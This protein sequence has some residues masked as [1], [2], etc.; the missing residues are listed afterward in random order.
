MQ[1][2]SKILKFLFF[3]FIAVTSHPVFA[4]IKLEHA[5]RKA[6]ENHP[7][8][9]AG[10]YGQLGQLQAEKVAQ[11]AYYPKL[12]GMGLMTAGFPGSAAA[13]GVA[14][15]MISPFHRGPSAGF[16][17][18]QNIWDFGR[19]TG[20]VRLAEMETELSKADIG[21]TGLKIG[22]LVQEAYFLCARDRSLAQV[23]QRVAQESALVEGEVKN[24]VRVGQKSVVDQY[25]LKSQ[26]EEARTVAEDYEKRFELD[27]RR[28]AYLA[29]FTE[30]SQVLCPILDESVISSEVGLPLV[31]VASAVSPWVSMAQAQLA[32]SQSQK[33]LA[34]A[35]FSP[36]L[37]GLASIG[38]MKDS[39]L[40]LAKQNYSAA[41]AVIV[42]LFEGYKSVSQVNQADLRTM[43][44]EKNLQ[45]A[46]FAVDE[47]NLNYDRGIESAKLRISHLKAEVKLAESGFQI[48]KK[49][50][51]AL[52]GNLVDLRE[53]IRD[54]ARVTSEF[55][56]A[57]YDFA[58]QS[59]GKALL[60]G[61]WSQVIH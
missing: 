19:T 39:E 16:L 37:V 29:G 44:S 5:I 20:A 27:H 26:T 31:P 9:K 50:Y 61:Q 41:L 60:N 38:W 3:S 43:Q 14:G 56:V 11:A 52:Q 47:A 1:K 17:I 10:E 15:L 21:L 22:Q 55:Q 58:T 8:L 30:T 33:S 46:H 24:F 45:A 12:T 6:I 7:A 49:R 25:L 4:E 40:G 59:T 34:Q 2:P 53:S 42:P 54:L 51:S 48:A 36:K 57:L 13:T 23:Y 32:V 18:E 28:L 35:E